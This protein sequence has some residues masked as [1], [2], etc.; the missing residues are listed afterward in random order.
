LFSAGQPAIFRSSPPVARTFCSRCGTPL[1]YQHES[2]R[3]TIDIT[4]A[5]LDVPENFPPEREIW[6]EHRLS[7]EALNA[8]LPHYPRTRSEGSG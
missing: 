4:T 1:T 6:T 7:W 8:E 2:D 5:S 3:D